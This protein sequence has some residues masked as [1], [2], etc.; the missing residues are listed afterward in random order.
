M[1]YRFFI[2]FSMNLGPWIGGKPLG[3]IEGPVTGCSSYRAKIRKNGLT[4]ASK[5]FRIG[6][7]SNKAEAR[8]DAKAWLLKTSTELGL[9]KNR[10]RIC[11]DVNGQHYE[12][13]LSQDKT[14][15]ISLEDLDAVNESGSYRGRSTKIT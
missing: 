4:V 10:Y 11:E 14:M 12:V 2:I 7:Y 6:N 8:L 9:T 13:E 3:S 1:G 15:K 5:S